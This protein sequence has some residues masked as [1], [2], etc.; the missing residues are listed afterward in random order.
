VP[1]GYPPFPAC[2][3]Q[4]SNRHAVAILSRHVGKSR[5]AQEYLS[6]T[7][8]TIFV[9]ADDFPEFCGGKSSTA[10]ALNGTPVSLH[11]Y[12]ENC[13]AAMKRASDAGATVL[14]PPMDMLWGDRYGV[15]T[16]PYG[17]KWSFA[18]HI[19]DLTPEQMKAAMKDAFAPK[20]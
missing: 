7:G 3:V 6:R 4:W 19:K 14:M 10:T 16:D 5:C 8:L 11:Q 2:A 13:D 18:T 15:V 12:V 1:S 20:S 9:A 17:H